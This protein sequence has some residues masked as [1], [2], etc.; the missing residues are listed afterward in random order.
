MT[1][2]D[3]RITIQD[4]DILERNEDFN[5]MLDTMETRI[6]ITNSATVLILND[7]GMCYENSDQE[8]FSSTTFM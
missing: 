6:Q 8:Y 1:T 7:D 2:A 3:L 5:I 4:D